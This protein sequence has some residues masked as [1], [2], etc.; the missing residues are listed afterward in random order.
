M[1]NVPLPTNKYLYDKNEFKNY[2]DVMRK[3]IKVLSLPVYDEAT[4]TFHSPYKPANAEEYFT[5]HQ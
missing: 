2:I 4:N 3:R 5:N 1:W